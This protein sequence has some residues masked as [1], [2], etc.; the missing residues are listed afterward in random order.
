MNIRKLFYV[1]LLAMT[2]AACGHSVDKNGTTSAPSGTQ[3]TTRKVL[4][5]RSAMNPAVTS[6]VPA[7]DSMGMEFVPVY[8]DEDTSEGSAI[9]ISPAVQENL[10]VRTAPVLREDLQRQIHTVGYVDY[11]ES[12]FVRL[13]TRAAGWIT[14]LPIASSGQVVHSGQ[15]LFRLYSPV[16]VTAEQEYIQALAGSDQ[17]LVAAARKR[18]AAFDV[19]VSEVERLERSREAAHS[20]PYYAPRG[21]VVQML[22]ARPG[23][24]V[25]P[26][27]EV[28]RLAVLSK[29]WLVAEVFE[30][31]SDWVAAGDAATARFASASSDTARGNVNFVDTT[32]DPVTRSLKVR[33]TFSNPGIAL[34]PNMYADVVIDGTAERNVLTIPEDALIR[35]GSVDRVILA[36]GDGRFQVQPVTAGIGSGGRIAILS[37][38]QAGETVVTSGQFLIDS[39]ASLN[40]SLGRLSVGNQNTA[41]KEVKP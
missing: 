27:T 14:D 3:S 5:Y 35:T 28:M 24:Y 23:L 1:L 15:L 39:E 7:K 17:S 13:H 31:D 30:R 2:L 19:P 10:G 20:L 25:T 6:P 8:A 16:L 36:L 4:F 18:L 21:G 11:D 33:M 22:N 29:V 40:A 41:V 9:R 38:L 34:K 26:D 12:D 37:G 32:I